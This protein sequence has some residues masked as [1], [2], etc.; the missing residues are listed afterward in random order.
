MVDFNLSRAPSR[1]LYPRRITEEGKVVWRYV[2]D[3]YTDVFESRLD[4]YPESEEYEREKVLWVHAI[5][6]YKTMCRNQRVQAFR[7]PS[8]N[9]GLHFVV[10]NTDH[11][12]VVREP[13]HMDRGDYCP[14]LWRIVEGRI[15]YKWYE[16]KGRT[17]ETWEAGYDWYDCKKQLIAKMYALDDK[18]LAI[19]ATACLNID[20]ELRERILQLA[21]VEEKS[22]TPC[23]PVSVLRPPRKAPA[24]KGLLAKAA[25]YITTAISKGRR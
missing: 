7:P 21:G 16:F 3:T 2:I 9:G 11:F 20:P 8:I 1:A 15:D 10:A 14:A 22:T 24:R 4:T 6:T 5:L 19:T 18:R 23:T 17:R 13:G 25:Q 12:A